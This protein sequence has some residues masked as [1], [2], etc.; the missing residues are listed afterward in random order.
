V[1]I[2]SDVVEVLQAKFETVLPHLDERQ[3]RLLMAAEARSLGHGGIAAVA[4]ATGASRSRIPQGVDELEAG[5]AP[6][7][8][9][10]RPGADRKRLSV[11]DPDLVDAL[12]GLVEPTRR[13]DPESPLCWTT[14]STRNLADELST[15]GHPVSPDTVARLLREQGFSLQAN[16]GFH[17]S[18]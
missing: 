6:S 7:Q 13:G 2:D 14:L 18:P 1:F 11:T 15:A 4:R 16:C 9:V 17:M 8:R 10:R 3:Q 5:E 12:S